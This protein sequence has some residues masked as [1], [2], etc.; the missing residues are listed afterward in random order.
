[1]IGFVR[2]AG[3]LAA[4]LVLGIGLFAATLPAYGDDGP[5]LWG[6]PDRRNANIA[7]FTHWTGMLQR[8]M[9]ERITLAQ[10]CLV[11]RF[12]RC[13]WQ[14]WLHFIQRMQ[15]RPQMEQLQAVNDYMNRHP[16]V[17]DTLNWWKTPGE[18]FRVDGNCK[19]YAIAKYLTLRLMG[20]PVEQL[21][22]VVL[23]DLNLRLAHAVL[24]VYVGGRILILDNQIPQV[25]DSTVIHHYQPIYSINETTWWLHRPQWPN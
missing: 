18:F 1:M 4:A 24:A 12:S 17:W 19:D 13:H 5:S 8:H 16:Y 9:Q 6:S 20:W 14:D 7:P 3:R 15:G 10:G 22:V 21:R 2:R 11:T 23:N 25:V